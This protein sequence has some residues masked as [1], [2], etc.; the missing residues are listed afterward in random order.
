MKNFKNYNPNTV[1]SSI[2]SNVNNFRPIITNYKTK[3]Q[4]YFI[5]NSNQHIRNEL[6]I[7]SNKEKDFEMKDN[8]YNIYQSNENEFI[9][10]NICSQRSNTYN[11]INQEKKIIQEKIGNI[12]Y[13]IDNNV[14]YSSGY[15]N[16][17]SNPLV[18]NSLLNNNIN[19]YYIF[20]NSK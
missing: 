20:L 19:N 9:N 15:F 12:N 13:E 1:V 5:K 6:S 16:K 2:G 8:Q 4:N 10:D 11:N 14:I 7:S 18:N 3:K 17:M